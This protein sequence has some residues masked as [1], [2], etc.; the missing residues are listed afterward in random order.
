L[1]RYMGILFQSSFGSS[2][3]RIKSVITI[4][5]P[6]EIEILKEGGKRHAFI[7]SELKKLVVPGLSTQTLEDEAR[8]LLEESGD[9]G[10]F[11]TTLLA[12][13]KDLILLY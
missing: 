11:L 12:A 5:T 7:L 10:A 8:K 2:I 4:K 3:E 6:E 1:K 9:K 13:Q